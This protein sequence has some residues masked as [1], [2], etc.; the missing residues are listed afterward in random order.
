MGEACT[1]RVVQPGGDSGPGARA[2]AYW[3]IFEASWERGLMCTAPGKKGLD[4]APW[5][6]Q[7]YAASGP[8]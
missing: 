7:A 2:G 3:G 4:L 5:R 8:T 6:E 1:S